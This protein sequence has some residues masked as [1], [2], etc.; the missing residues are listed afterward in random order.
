M[1]QGRTSLVV[2]GGWWKEIFK[3]RTVERRKEKEGIEQKE[4]AGKEGGE[5]ERNGK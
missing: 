5:K 3:N 4:E 1:K 2:L